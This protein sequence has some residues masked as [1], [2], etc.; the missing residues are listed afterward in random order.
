MNLSFRRTRFSGS[1]RII[2]TCSLSFASLISLRQRLLLGGFLRAS[3]RP[4]STRGVHSNSDRPQARGPLKSPEFR[5]FFLDFE[6]FAFGY[7]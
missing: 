5:D 4:G 7:R 6:Q 3:A 2:L 1:V